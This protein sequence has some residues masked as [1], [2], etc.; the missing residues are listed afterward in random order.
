MGRWILLFLCVIIILIMIDKLKNKIENALKNDFLNEKDVLY[1]MVLVRKCID[2]KNSEKNENDKIKLSSLKFY[3]DW[4][5]HPVLDKSGNIKNILNI[6][7]SSSICANNVTDEQKLKTKEFYNFFLLKTFRS[8]LV[9]FLNNELQLN[10]DDIFNNENKWKNFIKNLI[11]IIRDCP[12]K[13][14][15]PT[16]MKEYEFI[17]KNSENSLE[18]CEL[19]I[20]DCKS[21]ISI[22]YHIGIF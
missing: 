8:E 6:F 17:L 4:C 16:E 9:D 5:L 21:N 19:K 11:K 13:F 18:M 10:A 2:I 15:D 7:N 20:K 22:S 12:I 3:C 1:F 14:K